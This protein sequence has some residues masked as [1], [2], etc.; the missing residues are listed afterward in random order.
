ME[1]GMRVGV[2]ETGRS[3]RSIQRAAGGPVVP[4]MAAAVG[5]PWRIGSN[6][7]QK[8]RKAMSGPCSW[9][10]SRDLIHQ[11]LC[12]RHSRI[13]HTKPKG[14]ALRG[15]G[16]FLPLCMYIGVCDSQ[17]VW[18]DRPAPR[19]Q[20]A[21]PRPRRR[22]PAQV[23]LAAGGGELDH[24][25]GWVGAHV[26]LVVGVRVEAPDDVQPPGEPR[27]GER[28]QQRAIGQVVQERR[29]R[30]GHGVSAAELPADSGA[31]APPCSGGGG[32]RLRLARRE[33]AGRGRRRLWE[34]GPRHKGSDQ[35]GA[36]DGQMRVLIK[37]RAPRCLVKRCRLCI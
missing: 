29:R 12:L 20:S 27:H 13:C 3:D 35:I 32:W 9:N 7:S 5:M 11:M 1:S 28:G 4:G 16:S 25:T 31:A 6:D 10:N 26:P 33:A 24:A 23:Q 15:P 19:P 34:W 8:T 21:P 37:C 17:C 2:S 22:A 14:Q 18:T 30:L 36:A